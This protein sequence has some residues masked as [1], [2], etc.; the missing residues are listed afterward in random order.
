MDNPIVEAYSSALR[1][2]EGRAPKGLLRR[3][4]VEAED[5][6]PEPDVSE[7]RLREHLDAA[8]QD[9]RLVVFLTVNMGKWEHASAEEHPWTRG[10]RPNSPERR[11][12]VIESLKLEPETADAFATHFPLA[13]GDGTTVIAGPWEPWYTMGVQRDRDFYWGHYTEYLRTRRNWGARAIETLDTATTHVVERLIDPS[14]AKAGQTKG[15]VVGYVQSGKTANFTGVIAKAIDAG[16]RLVIVMTGTT[17]LLREQT[18]RRLDMELVG[19]ENILRGADESDPSVA[20]L[21]DYLGDEDWHRDRFIRHGVRPSEHGKPD[22]HRMTTRRFDYRRLQQ[23]LPAL[24]F[25]RRDRTKQLWHPENL[26][27]SD[28]RLIIVKKNSSVLNNLVKDLKNNADKLDDIPTLIIDDESDQASVNTTDPRKWKKEKKKRTAI[29][30]HLSDLLRMLPRAQY[31][32]YT[33]TPF[34]NVFVDPTDDEDIFPKD[35]LISLERPAGY[36]GAEDFHDLDL[37]TPESEKTFANSKERAHVRIVGKEAGEDKLQT[38]LDSFVLAGTIKLYREAHGANTFKHH[39]MLVHEA[40]RKAVHKTRTESIQ[41]LWHTSGYLSGH[42]SA[43]LRELFE[44][45]FAPVAAALKLDHLMPPAFD[46]LLPFLGVAA[47]RIAPNGNPVLVVN[48]D[49]DIEQEDL[50]FDKRS[51][52]RIL[53]GGN[54]LARGFTVEGLT[55]TYYS[56]DVGH[57]EALMQMGR[58]FGF[59]PGYRDLVRLF[60]TAKVRDAF[61]AAC[62]D[63]EEFRREL[64]QYA[65]MVDG[66]PLITPK[67]IQPQ[68]MRHGGLRPTAAN[69]MYNAKLVERRTRTKEP[70]SG[71]PNLD[72][73]SALNHNVDACRPLLTATVEASLA[74]T[75]LAFDALAGS[76]THK[77]MVDVLSELKW[78]K[79]DTFTADLAWIASL[80]EDVIDQWHIVMPQQ[81]TGRRVNIRGIGEFTV[82]GRKVEKQNRIRGNSESAHRRALDGDLPGKTPTSGYA[83]LYPVMDK[84]RTAIEVDDDGYPAGVVMALM[85]RLPDATLSAGLKPLVYKVQVPGKPYYALVDEPKKP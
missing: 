29:N 44:A 16:Y 42:A 71:Y 41:D 22:I 83:L 46:D 9:D 56:R 78:A 68:V 2:M 63:E 75:G 43:R 13:K 1:A 47:R 49:K 35:Y 19:R 10:T 57:T 74:R 59:R 40:M 12:L 14:R 7:A 27:T 26:F 38:A 23:G 69:K 33:A 85:L 37:A 5:I 24:E 80:P 81:K 84:E 50:D 72:D 32:G 61:E 79:E 60:V 52:W 64:R 30:Q 82:H 6:V 25:E 76:V 55:V 4:R 28:A 17:N 31:V 15:L 70:S 73:Q 54:S 65:T 67:D 66:R 53:V 62:R 8:G 51:V 3:A 48:S 21:I 20:Q 34:A 45:D 39:T 36:M 18:Q 77:E 58:W 11:Q